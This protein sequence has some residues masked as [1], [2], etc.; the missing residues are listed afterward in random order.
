LADKLTYSHEAIERVVELT[1]RQ[2]YLMQCLCNKVFDYAVQTK[3][4]SITLGVVND[5]ANSLVRDNE[6]FASLW[7]YAG[8]GPTLGRRRRQLALLLC[9]Q[10]ARQG[11]HVNFGTLQ[12]QLAQVGVDV[13]DEALDTDLAYLRELELVDFSGETGDGR[14]R[15]TI[16][17]MADWI[18]QQQDANV[19]ASRARA[20]AEEENA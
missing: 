20:E 14:Y 17:L 12:E 4:R 10:S 19:I 5:A 8:A 9:A 15:M 11:T 2:P 3:S 16:P 13:D 18:E 1:A 6:H 7:D